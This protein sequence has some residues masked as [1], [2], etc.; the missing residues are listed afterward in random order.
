MK[1][2]IVYTIV[3]FAALLTLNLN[4]QTYD[5]KRKDAAK[6]NCYRS[7]ISDNQGVVESAIFISLQFKNRFPEENTNKILDAL[8]DL[9]KSS[10][11]PRISYKAQLARLYFKNTAWFKNVEVKSLYDEQKTFEQI[12][13]TL[14]NS[15]VA[16]NN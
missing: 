13:E 1:E 10:E 4:A 3:L 9:A 5:G 15:I 7:L 12:A 16:S 8:D 2:K 14:N 6:E 11:I